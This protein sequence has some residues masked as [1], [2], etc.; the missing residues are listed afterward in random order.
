MI[1]YKNDKTIYPLDIESKVILNELPNNFYFLKSNQGAPILEET[2]GPE[3]LPELIGKNHKRI[4]RKILDS[5]S[6]T[7]LLGK[8]GLGKSLIV[9]YAINEFVKKYPVIFV[10]KISTDVLKKFINLIDKKCVFV[11]DEFEKNFI[12]VKS[13][14]EH[15]EDEEKRRQTDLLSILD[16]MYNHNHIF[17]LTANEKKK[18][19]KYFFNRPK[20]IRYIFKF[21]KVDNDIIDQLFKDEKEKKIIKNLNQLRF[22]NM[23]L[24]FYIKE[25]L[26]KGYD[27]SEVIQDIGIDYA[28]LLLYNSILVDAYDKEYQEHL[29]FRKDFQV[30]IEERDN[31][32]YWVL[33]VSLYNSEEKEYYSQTFYEYHTE[34][35]TIN[36]KIIIENTEY[37]LTFKI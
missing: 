8:S 20:R 12:D 25:E 32:N 28:I 7:L 1:L 17:L 3:S 23:D 9:K 36:D 22:L 4:L 16:G 14:E 33:N 35:Y 13:P 24:L 30:F 15:F 6:T 18:I 29:K 21:D 5:E 31:I 2:E 26:K 27:I 19:N 10:E 37:R 11:F 34:I